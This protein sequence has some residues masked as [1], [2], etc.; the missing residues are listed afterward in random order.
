[1]TSVSYKHEDRQWD[2]RINVQSDDYL[3][4]ITE[5]IMLEHAAGKFKYILVSGCEI[6]T[7]PNHSD[8]QVRHVHIAVIFHNRSSKS[9]IIKNWGIVEGNGYYL[10]PRNRDL[11]YDGWR[12]HHTKTFSKVDPEKLVIFEAGSLPQDTKAPKLERSNEEKKR[13]V[14]EILVDMR[15]LIESNQEEEAFKKYPRNYLL[16]GARLK[17]MVS[18]KLQ[19][20]G[21]HR[22]P[23]IYVFGFPGTGKTSI[24]KFVYPNMY[25]KDLSNRFFDLYDEKIHTHIMLEDLDHENVEKLGI[26]FLKTLCDEAGFPIDQKY[27]TPQLTRSTILVT[28]NFSIDEIIPHDL[29]GMEQTKAA[30]YRRFWHVRIDNFLRILGLKMIDKW[31][32]SKLKKQ[33]NEDPSK[34]YM[35]YDYAQDCPTGLPV[36]EPEYYQKLILDHYYK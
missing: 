33:G 21:D 14:D 3:Q 35:D 25:K 17:A 10:V 2:C 26:Q 24:M 16:Y 4:L 23:H 30:L 13:K 20:C 9:A 11:S 27:K 22:N 1:M 15:S 8:Y 18:Q 6:G 5:N 34:L 7:K 28:S 32:R 12:T 19:S 31:D 36:K 29:L